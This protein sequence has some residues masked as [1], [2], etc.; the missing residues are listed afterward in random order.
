MAA[1]SIYDELYQVK[2]KDRG[3]AVPA[4]WQVI[5]MIG[6]KPDASQ[7]KPKARGSAMKSFKEL[8][9][10]SSKTTV[11]EDGKE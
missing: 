5:Y 6:W 3:T 10:T 11:V 4:T 8:N 1:S 7:P 9:Q 2:H